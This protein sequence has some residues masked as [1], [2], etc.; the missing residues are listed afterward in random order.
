MDFLRGKRGGTKKSSKGSPEVSPVRQ[1][2]PVSPQA[3]TPLRQQP[4]QQVKP[5]Q[6][7]QQQHNHQQQ[8]QQQSRQKSPSGAEARSPGSPK[9]E[10]G[11]EMTDPNI[12]LPF[13]EDGKKARNLSI[14]RSGRHKLKGKQR[15]SVL[16]HE[17]YAD[18]ESSPPPQERGYSSG[19]ACRDVGASRGKGKSGHPT[20][21]V[22]G[23]TATV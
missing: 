14:S 2:Q 20:L 10:N 19:G 1:K 18:P 15:L 7:Q 22:A 11:V 12:N 21:S 16:Q 5:Q 6:Q 9:S 4:Q 8:Q 17:I 3:A 13:P 23:P